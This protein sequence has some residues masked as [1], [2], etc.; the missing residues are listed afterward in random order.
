MRKSTILLAMLFVVLGLPGYVSG[1]TGEEMDEIFDFITYQCK[2]K[3]KEKHLQIRC[4]R[5][6]IAQNPQLSQGRDGDLLLMGLDCQVDIAEL[7]ESGAIDEATADSRMEACGDRIMKIVEMRKQRADTERR[8]DVR[9]G[10]LQGIGEA[11][12]NYKP[13][14]SSPPSRTNCYK[15]GNMWQCDT[16]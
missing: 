2:S 15:I 3:Y 7:Q 10:I 4:V 1:I 12:Q 9:R 14:P 8:A 11:L 5:D 16:Y 13:P 6:K